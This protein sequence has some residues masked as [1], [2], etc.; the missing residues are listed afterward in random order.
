MSQ[1]W[2]DYVRRQRRIALRKPCWHQVEWSSLSGTEQKASNVLRETGEDACSAKT[3]HFEAGGKKHIEFH[4]AFLG[5]VSDERYDVLWEEFSKESGIYS[6]RFDQATKALCEHFHA[7]EVCKCHHSVYHAGQDEIVYKACVREGTEW[8][9]RGVRGLRK[10]TGGPREMVSVFQDEERGFGLPLC[11]DELAAVNEFQQHEG[12]AAREATPGMRFLL[13]GE[14]SE[15]YWGFAEFEEQVIDVMDF[16]EVLEHNRQIAIEVGRS[17]GHTKYLPEDQHVAN[18]NAKYGGKQRVLRD[19][20]MTEECLGPGKATMYLNGE[21]WSTNFVPELTTRIVDC[22]VKVGEVQSMS[23][24]ED[25]P[26]P[27]Y[28][29]EAPAKDTKVEKANKEKTSVKEGYVGKAKGMGQVLWECGWYVDGMSTITNDTENN[30]G[31]V[32]GHLPDFRNERTALQDTVESQGHIL[33]LPPKFHLEVADVGIEYSW[34][35]SKLKYRR[36][37]H[38]EVT[39]HLHRNIVASMCPET[40]LTLSRVS[41]FARRMRDY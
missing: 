24:A 34:G 13:P 7:P 22:K 8:V 2:G 39:K 4:V 19:S 14:N 17:A 30:I 41:R 31:Q 20:A 27:F 35:I 16:L 6:V 26:P 5:E 21:K 40:V 23:F 29:W 15:G 18:M 25:T 33:V 36:E 3:H 9:I 37:L 1:D 11:V 10:K 32:L 12:R 38:D 28:D